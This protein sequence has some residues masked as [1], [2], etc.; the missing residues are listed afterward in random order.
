MC[1]DLCVNIMADCCFVVVVPF[2]VDDIL[3]SFVSV[4]CM[5]LE[6]GGGGKIHAFFNPCYMLL[7]VSRN[8]SQSQP[9]LVHCSLIGN[10]SHRVNANTDN[11][12]A[13]RVQ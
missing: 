12:L 6:G 2:D 4:L 7:A 3:S 1:I 13:G 11:T 9:I 10:S 5:F 8:R